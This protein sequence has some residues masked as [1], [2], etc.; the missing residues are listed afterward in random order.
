MA[1]NH[2]QKKQLMQKIEFGKI[3]LWR[4]YSFSLMYL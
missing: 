1:L 3:K 2:G 4:K